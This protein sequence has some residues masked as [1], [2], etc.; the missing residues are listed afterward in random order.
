MKTHEGQVLIQHILPF[1]FLL[2]KSIMDYA[3][4]CLRILLR[5]SKRDTPVNPSNIWLN[6]LMRSCQRLVFISSILLSIGFLSNPW[7][8]SLR[9]KP[10]L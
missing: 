9:L 10:I 2:E 3:G 8:Y 6:S 1:S 7:A 4:T 5:V